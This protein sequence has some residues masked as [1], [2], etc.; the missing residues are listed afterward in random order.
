MPPDRYTAGQ[1]TRVLATLDDQRTGYKTSSGLLSPYGTIA[2]ATCTPTATLP[3]FPIG[4]VRVVFNDLNVWTGDNGSENQTYIDHAYNQQTYVKRRSSYTIS[5]N[6]QLNAQNVKA[7]I[8]YNNDGDFADVGEEVF[9]HGY[10]VSAGDE[11]HTGSII[12]PNTAT[13]CAFLRMRVVSEFGSST[14]T[15]WPCGP[16]VYGQAEDYGVYVISD[17]PAVTS[18]VT[19]T[20]GATAS[21]LSATGTNLKWYTLATGGTGSSTAIIPSTASAGTTIYYV[22]QSG[23][24]STQCESDRTPITVVVNAATTTVSPP[25]VTSPIYYCQGAAA[26]ALTATLASATDTLYWYTVPT[27]GTGSTTAPTPTTTSAGTTKYYVSEKNTSGVES[28]RDSIAVI[29]LSLIHI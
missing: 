7:F 2:S 15:N 17:T 19:Y 26:A 4:P 5:I 6:T 3:G 29:I 23:D 18:P 9:S 1:R 24:G 20:V 22:S 14:I 21:A 16:Y 13:T 11:M 27:G 12:I 8:D 25:T 10:T 28:T